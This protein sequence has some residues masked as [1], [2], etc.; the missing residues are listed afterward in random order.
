VLFQIHSGTVTN[1]EA[2]RPG[3][4]TTGYQMYTNTFL[5]THQGFNTYRFGGYTSTYIFS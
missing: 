4:P 1:V 2:I 3:Y 5:A